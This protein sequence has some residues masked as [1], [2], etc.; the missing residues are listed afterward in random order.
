MILL[1]KLLLRRCDSVIALIRLTRRFDLTWG[2]TKFLIIWA[3][4]LMV[5]MFVFFITI[6]PAIGWM[7]SFKY[8]EILWVMSFIAAIGTN[9]VFEQEHT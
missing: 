5:G 1:F 9:I 6:Y 8:W 7:F 3:L 4:F 2:F